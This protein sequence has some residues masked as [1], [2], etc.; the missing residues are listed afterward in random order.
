MKIRNAMILRLM[1]IV[2][3][4]WAG[5]LLKAQKINV[6]LT[7]P[8]PYPVY[9]EDVIKF[10]SQSIVTLTNIS[11][12]A[13]QVKLI[14]TLK[15][16]NGVS[17]QVSLDF[18]PAA[19]ISLAAGET[20]VLTGNTLRNHFS[21]LTESQISYS[22]VSKSTLMQTE[23][24][25]EGNYQLC[26]RAYEYRTNEA[27]SP[28]MTGCANLFISYYDP[29]IIIN[30]MDKS[31]VKA[32][33]PQ[34][35]TINW[36]PAGLPQNTRYRLEM[37][38]MTLN[39]LLNPNEAFDNIAIILNYK[40][41]NIIP[42]TLVYDMTL[43]KLITG[44]QY[45]LRVTAYDPTGKTAFK[46]QGKSP[47]TVFQYITPLQNQNPEFASPDPQNPKPP[48]PG[49]GNIKNQS[50][51]PLF[52]LSAC[53]KP[54]NIPNNSAIN[55]QGII[56]NYDVIKIGDHQLRLTSVSW[57]GNLLSGQ[58]KI[59]NSWLKV[60]ILVE[61]QNLKVNS[62]KIVI[63]GVAKA[64]NDDNVPTDWINDLGNVSF[65]GPQIQAL[66]AKLMGSNQRV[67]TW[68]YEN[69]DSIGLGMPLGINRTIGGKQ[70]LVAIVGMHFGVKGAGLNAVAE[71]NMPSYG[72]KLHL[73]ASG[74]CIDDMGFTKEAHLHLISD[75]TLNPQ[76]KFK[77]KFHKGIQNDPSKGCYIILEKEGFKELQLDG[78]FMIDATVA[79]PVDKNKNTVEAPFKIK[80]TDPNNFILSNVSVT[81]FELVKLPGFQIT[82]SNVS[83]DHSETDNPAG[84]SF[85]TQSY[86]TEGN[87]W[88]G[89]YFKNITIRL[90]DKLH[91]NH[92]I[93][94]LHFLADKKGFSG[95]IDI[96][97]VFDKDKGQ[98][99]EKKW[100][101]SM[102]DF[103]VRIIENQLQEAR[104]K[105][106]IR[107]PI[108]RENVFLAYTANMSLDNND[109]L[110]YNFS[111]VNQ[112]DI[113]FPAIIAKGKILPNTEILVD[114]KGSG[115][116]PEFHLYGELEFNR[117]FSLNV[118]GV[119]FKLDKVSVSDL[120]VDKNG[121]GLGP[122][123]AFSYSYNSG[124]RTFH[125][126]D[127]NLDTLQFKKANELY[128]GFSL[129]LL[130][131]TNTV[132]ART[133]FSIL[134]DYGNNN[135][136]LGNVKLRSLG[137]KGDISVATLDGAIE[138]MENDPVYGNGFSGAV[139]VD[140]KLG[141][142]QES[143]GGAAI[144]IKFGR[145]K[146]QGNTDEYKYFFF[147]GE[148]GVGVGIPLSASLRLYGLK[149]AMYY[150]MVMD[151]PYSNPVPFKSGS[152][153]KFGILAGVD[154]GLVDK[155]AFH[156]KPQLMVQFGTK[157]GLDMI[158]IFGDAY[159]FTPWKSG[160]T[161]YPAGTSPVHIQM[162]ATMDFKKKVFDFDS[163]ITVKY[164]VNNPAITANGSIRMHV[165]GAQNWYIKIGEPGPGANIGVKLNFLPVAKKHYF[166][167]G[168]NLPGMPPVP[169]N[170]ASKLS[171][172][173]MADR[174]GTDGVDNP[175][176]KFALGS[177]VD[178]NTGDLQAWI[179]YADF[180]A[181]YGYDVALSKGWGSCGVNS[182][183]L[184]GQAYAMLSADVGVR[185]KMFNKERKFKVAAVS[186]ALLA[187]AALPN[188]TYIQADVVGEA[189]F[190]GII[191]GKFTFDVKYGSK[192]AVKPAGQQ[193]EA[194]SGL[195][196][197]QDIQPTG[198]GVHVFTDPEVSLLFSALDHKHYEVQE[199]DDKDNL[200]TR[201]FRFPVKT[202]K[203]VIDDA[204]SPENGKVL[205]SWGAN[206]LEG[207]W[208]RN[209]AGDRFTYKSLKSLPPFTN[210]KITAEVMVQEL[211]G[212][213]WQTIKAE[214]TKKE[215]SF[216]TGND[217]DQ[218]VQ[219][220][221]EV[222]YPAFGQRYY[223]QGDNF[224]KGY[225]QLKKSQDAV[226]VHNGPAFTAPTFK[227]RFIPVGGGN[228][229]EGKFDGYQN[230]RVN[231]SHPELVKGKMYVMQLVKVNPANM[232]K[233]NEGKP[234]LQGDL[235]FASN[236]FKDQITKEQK[237]LGALKL[238]AK[239]KE[240]YK[241]PFGVSI[242]NNLADKLNKLNGGT[243]QV[244]LLNGGKA[245]KVTVSYTAAQEQFD[246]A[247]EAQLTPQWYVGQMIGGPAIS[248]NDKGKPYNQDYLQKEIYVPYN[249]I[250]IPKAYPNESPV[251]VDYT[252]KMTNAQPLMSQSEINNILKEP[253]NPGHAKAA[254]PTSGIPVIFSV[255]GAATAHVHHHQMLTRLL[256]P[257]TYQKA[258]M[259]QLQGDSKLMNLFNKWM[260]NPAI[261]QFKTIQ[262]GQYHLLMH[263]N[264]GYHHRK[265]WNL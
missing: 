263:R 112:N 154:I 155:N 83:I 23:K 70:Q 258:L 153:T 28:E 247:D 55:G 51:G 75:Y 265:A 78:N 198:N 148:L 119:P 82:V 6:T 38:D 57:N 168:Y 56:N 222:M 4:C 114:Q 45:A 143:A 235:Q 220:N 208:E 239:E 67:M 58:G 108:T 8:Q 13:Q 238:S 147:S 199:Y 162:E 138:I 205:A 252:M 63:D 62:D 256:N 73:G 91:P 121:V 123:G 97:T 254:A 33:N 264:A 44:R 211:I 171:K 16:D 10:R 130:G 101:F 224:R 243:A 59:I 160:F 178:F 188:P 214:G 161:P 50:M 142:N 189:T 99:G 219:S 246:V 165:A 15:G 227:V 209:N 3:F 31:D 132:G 96:P 212:Q 185:T 81:P 249:T 106:D 129:D 109:Q 92:N 34:F 233:N 107:V 250:L 18:L 126:F 226:F 229:L 7:V 255:E 65:G 2:L 54:L 150:N 201:K 43:P 22:G 170:I 206:N 105:G 157:S 72:Q 100:K 164:P 29:P 48:V 85:P 103:Y 203:M 221:I 232:I 12:T 94:C 9:L 27:L 210:I 110:K 102:K 86:N 187:Q 122:D 213:N 248:P 257:N 241:Y 261:Q 194:L 66:I 1:L 68:P 32:Q 207:I 192:C 42:N 215:V 251:E 228:V 145:M 35:L 186:A 19:P 149:G 259:Q 182:W 127:I 133:G 30:P 245:S 175:D 90:P 87:L 195:K 262:A 196:Y 95:I 139:K 98:M 79:K 76:G 169:Y 234:D 52:S 124:Q 137:I 231:F 25:P 191:K 163:G 5:F 113:E 71:I 204:A 253:S 176:L 84:I 61:F 134:T 24:L 37:V 64:R 177:L 46:N 69:M 240:L 218:I 242:Y 14:A 17:A 216:K 104:F 20:R 158:S 11:G 237:L 93:Q 128:L 180:A 193:G 144:A 184:E 136:I 125:G 116:E 156:A 179:L 60:P 88:K 140:L 141:Q 260:Q 77:L 159:A 183:Y 173:Y 225:I 146:A 49:P 166:M 118:Q 36:T 111:M 131:E 89:F 172:P 117:K 80:L 115:L 217:P 151:G 202:L 236:D 26:I 41:E 47:V 21:N 190:M 74:V 40:K 244:Q 167:A 120:V 230:N 200:V 152:D 197:V 174:A 53:E 223:L 39:N 181:T 135:M